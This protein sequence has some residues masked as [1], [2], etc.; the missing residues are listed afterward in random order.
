VEGFGVSLGLVSLAAEF[1]SYYQVS[2]RFNASAV[3]LAVK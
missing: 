1:I 3:K 2:F